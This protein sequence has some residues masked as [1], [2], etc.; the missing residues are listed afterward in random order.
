MNMYIILIIVKYI[1]GQFFPEILKEPLDFLRSLGNSS[2]TGI[3]YN[4]NK[5]SIIGGNGGVITIIIILNFEFIK[6]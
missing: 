5:R 6:K 1:N 2:I 4:F 3:F